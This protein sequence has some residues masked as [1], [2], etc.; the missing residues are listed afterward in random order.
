[1][2]G[3]KATWPRMKVRSHP[4]ARAN[5]RRNCVPA[6]AKMMF[7]TASIPLA[8]SV[9]HRLHSTIVRPFDSDANYCDQD[10]GDDGNE[11]HDSHIAD[12]S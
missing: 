1:M 11:A 2:K 10:R 4:Q 8:R 9:D 3:K 12:L 6:Y 5:F 7:V